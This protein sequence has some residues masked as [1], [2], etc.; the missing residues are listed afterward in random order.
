[1]ILF[2]DNHLLVLNKPAGLPTQSK[3]GGTDS[4]EIRGKALI[5]TKFLHAVHRLDTPVSGVVIFAKT[6]KALQR[7]QATFRSQATEK[8]YQAWVEGI[9]RKKQGTLEHWLIHGDKCALQGSS[10]DPKAKLCLLEYRCLKTEGGKTLVEITLKTGRYHQIRAQWAIVG[11]PVWGDQK[12]GS[13][14]PYPQEGIALHH[15]RCAITHPVRK[16]RLVFEA[17]SPLPH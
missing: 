3:P 11:H 5:K 14:V 8:I 10:G 6:Q 9:V 15:L 4:L 17:P 12:Y 13:R 1:M 2:E 16:E 7:L